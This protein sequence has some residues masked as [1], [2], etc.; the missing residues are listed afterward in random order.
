MPKLESRIS[1]VGSGIFER[2][3]L[4]VEPEALHNGNSAPIRKSIVLPR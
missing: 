4:S 3:T 2:R 1:R